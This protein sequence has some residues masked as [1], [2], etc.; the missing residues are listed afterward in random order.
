VIQPR[1]PWG[2]ALIDA[3]S[4][5]FVLPSS[6]RGEVRSIICETRL[7]DHCTVDDRH[8]I[9]L[10]PPALQLRSQYRRLFEAVLRLSGNAGCKRASA[11][12]DFLRTPDHQKLQDHGSVAAGD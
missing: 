10:A 7:E 6:R 4:D 2:S 5:A 11:P 8:C 1:S 3:A 12:L 9:A